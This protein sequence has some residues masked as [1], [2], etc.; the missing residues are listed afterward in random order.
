MNPKTKARLFAWSTK[1]FFNDYLILSLL[2]F[3]WQ[4][5]NSILFKTCYNKTKLGSDG[6]DT[7]LF[8]VQQNETTKTVIDE[9]RKEKKTVVNVWCKKTKTVIDDWY[10]KIKTG[11][12]WHQKLTDDMLWFVAGKPL[13]AWS[14]Q[15]HLEVCHDLELQGSNPWNTLLP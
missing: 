8:K 15:L 6:H 1:Y 13:T 9:W 11:D 4:I 3:K 5:N 10:K 12:L 2:K 14:A 7:I